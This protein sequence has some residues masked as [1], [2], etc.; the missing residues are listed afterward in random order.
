MASRDKWGSTKERTEIL[1]KAKNA[2]KKI[3]LYFAD[4]PNNA[5]FRYR[6][7]NVF[8]ATQ[9]SSK[10]Q[11]VFFFE[12]EVDEFKKFIPNVDLLIIERQTV[13]NGTVL[14]LI[15]EAR[16][17]HKKVLFSV[18]DLVF[19][20]QYLPILLKTINCKNF[21]YWGAYIASLAE[22]AKRTDGFITTNG[23]IGNLLTKKFRKDYRVIRNS[24]NDEQL[25]VKDI[26]KNPNKFII[27]YFSGSPTHEKDL[28]LIA[29]EIVKFLKN[30]NDTY[31]EIVGYMKLPKI[32]NTLSKKRII[33]KPPVDYLKLQKL[34]SEVQINLAP[35]Q[36]NDFSN[37]KSELKFFEAAAVATTTIAYPTYAFKN[38]IQHGETGFLCQP[39]EWYDALEYLY[40][41]P[42]E[43]VRI[44]KNAKKYCLKHYYGEEFLKEIEDAYDF[45]AK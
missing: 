9:K 19:S 7:Y 39:G 13:K 21:I 32:F 18:D 37:C 20:L 27:G 2:G 1:C 31:F 3:A 36:E 8:Q 24:L 5:P 40:A 43:N 45:F 41:H 14:K 33:I 10:W 44:A 15:K 22:V 29:P 38:S 12:R 25:G 23:Y 35:L 16:K 17:N 11:A 4:S 34:I 6:C 30:H 28:G 26:S 42:E